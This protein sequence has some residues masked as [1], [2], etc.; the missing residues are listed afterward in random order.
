VTYLEKYIEEKGPVLSG[1]LLEMLVNT[2]KSVSKEAAR[3]QLSRLKGNVYRVR[4]L[5]KDG[6]ILFYNK[7]IYGTEEYHF[8]LINALKKAG[9][10]YYTIL[11]SLDFHYGQIKLNHLPSYSINPTLDLKGHITFSTV[12]EKLKNLKVIGIDDDYVSILSS[13]SDNNPNFSRAKGIE[14]AKDFLLIQFNDWSRKIGLVAY[15]SSKFYSTFGNY[16]FNFVS[17]SYVGSLPKIGK[18]KITPAFVVADFLIGNT[19]NESQVDF[20][21]NKIR[22]LKFR[23]GVANFIPFLIVDSIDTKALN[24]LKSEGVVIGFVNEL[25]GSKYKDLLNS[26]INLVTNAGA[27]LKK[28]PEAYL[29]LILQLNKLVDGKTNNLRGDLF[30]FAVGYYQG[31]IC[32]S[33]DIGKLINY[34]GSQREIDVFG[35][36]ANKVIISECKGYNHKVDKEEIEVW[37]G[38]KIPVIRKWILD[39]PSISDRNIIFEFWS[40]G[41]YTDSAIKV[42]EKRKLSTKKYTIDYF[43]L[44]KM[45]V[46]SKEIKSKKFT[47]I[48]RDYYIKEI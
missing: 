10:Q 44:D 29:D 16:Q 12:L 47:E 36:L 22:T 3:K 35:L 13:I 1:E 15:N 48:L 30:E 14:L 18:D 34:K 6:Q 39:Q 7:D 20:Y 31:R 5:F 32:N 26:L 24:N 40:T 23:K 17:P 41:G 37:L 25:F 19:I 33:I 42:L 27:I 38:E 45:I 9:K 21:I 28:N 2:G 46:K 11:Q 43:D 4:G 8:G